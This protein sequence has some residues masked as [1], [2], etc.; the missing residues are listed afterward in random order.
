[1]IDAVSERNF[2]CWFFKT[3][4]FIN[5]TLCALGTE[6]IRQLHWQ[7]LIK[8]AKQL[9]ENKKFNDGKNKSRK[10]QN[11]FISSWLPALHPAPCTL[12]PAS[13]ASFCVF[14]VREWEKQALPESC[15]AVEELLDYLILFSLIGQWNWFFASTNC[16]A[17]WLGLKTVSK[18]H[19]V[20]A[21]QR[22]YLIRSLS[23]ATLAESFLT[24]LNLTT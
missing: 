5:F 24:T 18:Q 22:Y 13:L 3:I 17:I 16:T 20:H 4:N 10:I 14:L 7:A 15:Q 19:A 1:M 11:M 2:F 23:F 12:H 6:Q 21:Q 9:C 8:S